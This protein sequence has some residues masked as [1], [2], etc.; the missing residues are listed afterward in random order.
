MTERE[1][2]L[3]LVWIA[4]DDPQPS[5]R[6]TIYEKEIE[7]IEDFPGVDLGFNLMPSQGRQPT[8][9]ATGATVVYSRPE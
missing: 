2:G 8:E 5:V 3:V 1:E 7:I 4:V 9:I 6:K